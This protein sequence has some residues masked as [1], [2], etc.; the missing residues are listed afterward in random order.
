MPTYAPS[1]R[2]AVACAS[3]F[4]S[5]AMASP[6]V[7]CVDSM[8]PLLDL[9]REHFTE[10]SSTEMLLFSSV[11]RG[12]TVDYSEKSQDQRTIRS[13]CVS[14]LLTDPN[15][16][17]RVPY[18]GV[19][20]IG[21]S[22]D[23][24]LDLRDATIPF[25][26]S[27]KNSEV[28]NLIVLEYANIKNLDLSG[29]VVG[30]IL[31]D[32][33]ALR[34]DLRM[35]N[36]FTAHGAIFL[37]N[38]RVEGSFDLS[39]ARLLFSE[40]LALY[41]TGIQIH[42]DML[43]GSDF[44]SVGIV[45]LQ[46][47]QIGG[48]VRAFDA[49]FST[50][51]CCAFALSLK[52][53]KIGGD[54]ELNARKVTGGVS[55][56]N[57]VIAGNLDC[58]GAEFIKR[59]DG[60][61]AFL[62]DMAII[63]GSVFLRSITSNGEVSL[64]NA[65][66]GGD[67]DCQDAQLTGAEGFALSA[68]GSQVSGGVYLRRARVQGAVTF[69]GAIIRGN[70]EFDAGKFEGTN[71]MALRFDR[72]RI[73]GSVFFRSDALGVTPSSDTGR[74][75]THGEVRLISARIGGSLECDGARF[76]GKGRGAIIADMLQVDGSMFFRQGF[77]SEGTVSLTH[78]R[79]GAQLDCTKSNWSSPT[80][81]TLMANQ[82]EVGGDVIF[83]NFKVD[84]MV[85]LK[86]AN[87][88]GAFRWRGHRSPDDASLDLRA[89]RVGTLAD[90]T[91]SWPKLGDLYLN[92][93]QYSE[94][95][96]GSPTTAASRIDWISRQAML[97]R[98]Q[99]YE[100]LAAVLERMGHSN[101]ALNVRIASEWGPNMPSS[102]SRIPYLFQNVHG[103]V[104]DFGYRPAKATWCIAIVILVGFGVF[105]IGKCYG[106]IEPLSIQSADCAEESSKPRENYP[107]FNAFMYSIDLFVPLVNFYQAE[108]W[109]PSTSKGAEIGL[110]RFRLSL[111]SVCRAYLWV[112]VAMG[113][114][115]T[116]FLVLGISGLVRS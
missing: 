65:K 113:W 54:V 49:I 61:H 82:L 53:A 40:G 99:P 12:E 109:H 10:L 85:S 36:G 70:L 98:L 18:K 3:Y 37:R 90:E 44:H 42:G 81:D 96:D 9:A 101:D 46:G 74:F 73:D 6:P 64:I 91:E 93:F 33:L 78:A 19:A 26:L 83:E 15:A 69:S 100:Q 30:T 57:T 89:A 23:G 1:M 60:H 43:F 79:I 66:I 88:E 20:I 31:A 52:S 105:W 95:G 38:A 112:H 34:G 63:A 67:L 94:I 41:A 71:D 106:L 8:K 11:E 114:T 97:S 13:E 39:G 22:I 102:T 47:A 29:T 115:L 104:I 58:D 35:S 16:A 103:W 14:W 107:E 51:S 48:R 2:F 116:T 62:A 77:S 86:A 50:E 27:I 7:N 5:I 80:Q 84:G 25:P 45:R 4:G 75:E 76:V 17:G 32:R 87:I 59:K 108:Y 72:A 55:L 24:E 56:L 111:G 92:G 28:R 110:W 68:D 21:A